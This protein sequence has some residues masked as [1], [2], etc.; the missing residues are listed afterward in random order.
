MARV[1]ITRTTVPETGLNLTDATFATL[2]TGVDNGVEVPY[3]EDDLIAL[4]NDT[5][6]AAVY[7]I[8]V[9]QPTKYSGQSLVIPDKSVSVATGKTLLY[10]TAAIYR[11]TNGNLF[12]DCDVAGKVLALA[13]G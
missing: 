10:P 13:L 2:A 11:Q 1:P 3:G 9:A 5:G 12:I 6:G 7:T 8:K 4:K